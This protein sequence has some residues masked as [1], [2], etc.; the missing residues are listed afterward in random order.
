MHNTNPTDERKNKED[1]LA[2]IHSVLHQQIIKHSLS[3]S[4]FYL[5]HTF[6]TMLNVNPF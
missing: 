4:L 5:I 3:V 6:L 1:V 2:N